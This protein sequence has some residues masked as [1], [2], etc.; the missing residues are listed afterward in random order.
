MELCNKLPDSFTSDIIVGVAENIFRLSK[1]EPYLVKAEFRRSRIDANRSKRCAY[2][3]HQA[4][5]YYNKYHSNRADLSK[6]IRVENTGNNGLGFIFDIHG[7]SR[8]SSYKSDVIFGTNN[9]KSISQLLTV[10]SDAL[11]DDNGLIEFLKKKGYK[12][13]PQEKTQ[14]EIPQLNEGYTVTTYDSSKGV[15]GLQAVQ[16]ECAPSIRSSKNEAERK[17]FEADLAQFIIRFVSRFS[18]EI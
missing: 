17:I 1:K 14:K 4:K 7:T 2:E 5:K 3:V 8:I 9:G 12:T 10:N 16:I 15:N 18:Y 11:W 13:S 6:K